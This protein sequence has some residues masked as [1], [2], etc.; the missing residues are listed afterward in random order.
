MSNGL[1]SGLLGFNPIDL[2]Q[3]RLQQ[4]MS[5]IR[6][7]SN[8]YERIGASLGTLLGG[9]FLSPD[10]ELQ[11]VASIRK[12]IQESSSGFDPKDPA[13][14]YETMAINLSEAG[15]VEQAAQAS[16]KAKQLRAQDRDAAMKEETLD[17]NKQRLQLDIEKEERLG[18]Y[19]E[20][21]IADLKNK[22]G[23]DGRKIITGRDEFGG[24]LFYEVDEKTGSIKAIQPQGTAAKAAPSAS[25]IPGNLTPEQIKAELARRQNKGK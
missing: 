1:L 10:P 9:A 4:F 20:A 21:Q 12:I 7:A 24:T 15:F 18:R 25:N 17:I 22:A 3:Q 14:T 2:Q 5:P 19:T 6:Q 16:A 23:R 13:A 8:P 11:Q